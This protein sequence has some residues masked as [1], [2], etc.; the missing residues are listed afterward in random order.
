M[1]T[2]KQVSFNTVPTSSQHIPIPTTSSSQQ[3]TNAIPS[4]TPQQHHPT[5]NPIPTPPYSFTASSS[6]HPSQRL[7]EPPLWAQN[8]ATLITNQIK[9]QQDFMAN[10]ANIFSKEN[11]QVGHPQDTG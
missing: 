9:Q 2:H 1:P 4:T 3:S 8:I 5:I 7:Q 11:F 6:T 10:I